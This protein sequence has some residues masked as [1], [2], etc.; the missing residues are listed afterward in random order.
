MAGAEEEEA[1]L[2]VQLSKA[3]AALA[4]LTVRCEAALMEAEVGG[5]GRFASR[6]GYHYL[7]GVGM[8]GWAGH[9]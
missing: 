9:A 5:E 8:N 1:G 2:Q 3:N 7:R 6:P 4:D